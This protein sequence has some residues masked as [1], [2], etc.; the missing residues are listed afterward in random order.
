MKPYSTQTSSDDKAMQINQLVTEEH[1]KLACSTYSQ[2]RY[3]FRL[4]WKTQALFTTRESVKIFQGML[5]GR[6]GVICSCNQL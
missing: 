2:K 3:A 1:V 5:L 4:K 6:Y